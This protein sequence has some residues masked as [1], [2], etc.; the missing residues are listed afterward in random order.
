MYIDQN[1]I[2]RVRVEVDE[3]WDDEPGP[4]KAQ[5]GVHVR[6]ELRRAPFS[7]I[8]RPF[9]LSVSWVPMSHLHSAP[10]QNRALGL[11]LGGSRREKKRW[12]KN[13]MAGLVYMQYWNP[14]SHSFRCQRQQSRCTNHR[15]HSSLRLSMSS[16]DE[17]KGSSLVYS[18]TTSNTGVG[19][20]LCFRPIPSSIATSTSVE[21]FV[22]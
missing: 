7:I 4:P 9:R 17:L 18:T 8:V 1:E 6:R 2:V 5:E 3:F 15:V 20:Y 11:W 21:V 16:D 12:M 19:G 22:S 10:L 14:Q 13:R